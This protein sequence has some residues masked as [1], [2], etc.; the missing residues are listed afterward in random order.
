MTNPEPESVDT[1]LRRSSKV[2]AALVTFIG[3]LVLSGWA[4]NVVRL[5]SLAP[6]WPTMKPMTALSFALS[7]MSL[8]LMNGTGSFRCATPAPA[9]KATGRDWGIRVCAGAVALLSLLTLGEYFFGWNLVI[10]QFL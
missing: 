8:W 1:A 3:G 4:F 10:D 9:N 5:Q 6:G 7:G 2:A